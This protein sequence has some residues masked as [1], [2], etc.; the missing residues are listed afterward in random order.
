M[1]TRQGSRKSFPLP[2]VADKRC[3]K[4]YSLLIGAALGDPLRLFFHRKEHRGAAE[5]RKEDYY[6][7][8]ILA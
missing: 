3:S 2:L 7:Q 8:Y 5:I 1:E 4:V 6:K